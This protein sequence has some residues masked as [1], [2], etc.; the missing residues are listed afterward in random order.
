ML[1]ARGETRGAPVL[2][3]NEKRLT[4]VWESVSGQIMLVTPGSGVAT[5]HP[6]AISEGGVPSAAWTPTTL[7]IAYT[8]KAE[9]MQSVWVMRIM[10][11]K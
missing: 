6:V 5:Q 4:G 11:Q 10:G 3:N 1:V 7:V 9:H 8:A 2:I